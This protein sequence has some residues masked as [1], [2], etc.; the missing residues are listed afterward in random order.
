GATVV[1]FDK[2]GTLTTGRPQVADASDELLALAAAAEQGSAH[3]LGAAIREEAEVRRLALA[4]SDGFHETY[5]DGVEARVGGRTVR[6]GRAAFVGGAPARP[7][8]PGVAE[9]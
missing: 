1:V 2:T 4:H 7:A 5:G 3:P 8:V 6:V 9:V